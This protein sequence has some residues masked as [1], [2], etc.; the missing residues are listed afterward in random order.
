MSKLGWSID[1]LDLDVS[2]VQGETPTP[3]PNGAT[4]TFTTAAKFSTGSLQVWIDGVLKTPVLDYTEGGDNQSFSFIVNPGPGNR[5]N[6]PPDSS[7]ELLV[8]YVKVS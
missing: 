2:L 1:P 5:L 3:P 6:S 4:L 7:E 8:A